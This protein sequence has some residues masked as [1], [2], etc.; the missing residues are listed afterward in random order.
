MSF[1]LLVIS[2]AS[3]ALAAS[4][5]NAQVDAGPEPVEADSDA[6]P[7]EAPPS[8]PESPPTLPDATPL[9]PAPKRV[10]SA[11]PDWESAPPPGAASGVDTGDEQGDGL[12][13]VPRVLLFIPKWTLIIVASPVRLVAWTYERYQLRD[14]FKQ[15]FFNIDGTFGIYPV[16][17]FETGFG[18]NAGA[19]LVHK[20]LAG[21]GAPAARRVR[22]RVRADLRS[23]AVQRSPAGSPRLARAGGTP[24]ASSQGSVLRHRQR[25]RGRA[26]DDDRRPGR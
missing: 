19:R 23:E 11:V 16:A 3:V 24:S 12:L 22:R 8:A 10:V 25:R 18:L 17:F 26:G 20:N 13:W 15:I 14:R 6:A 2:L 4:S 5:A 1:R 9:P 21:R 7:P